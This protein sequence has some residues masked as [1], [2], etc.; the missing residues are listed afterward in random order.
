MFISPRNTFM[1]TPRVIHPLFSRFF[2]HLADSFQV[3][4]W[5][6]HVNTGIVIC[7][8]SKEKKPADIYTLSVLKLESKHISSINRHHKR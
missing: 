5:V 1:A 4:K 7:V 2:P 6:T 3:Q 8:D